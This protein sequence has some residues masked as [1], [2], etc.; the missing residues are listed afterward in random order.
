M[1]LEMEAIE[2]SLSKLAPSG[3][4]AGVSYDAQADQELMEEDKV[5]AKKREQRNQSAGF[6]SCEIRFSHSPK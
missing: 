3:W 1:T 6:F 4:K 2:T 5:E